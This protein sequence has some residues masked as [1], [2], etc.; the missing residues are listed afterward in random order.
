VRVALA[1][2]LVLGAAALVAALLA[3]SAAA[4]AERGQGG[5]FAR[6][7]GWLGLLLLGEVIA[8]LWVLGFVPL[9]RGQR[10]LGAD[11]P[12]TAAL[13]LLLLV[14]GSAMRLAWTAHRRPRPRRVAALLL[15][16]LAA[17]GLL[18]AAVIQV[19]RRPTA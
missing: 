17:A 4:A 14:L 3:W 8:G 10:L 9:S 6:R 1:F 2:H 5:P 16:H 15:A 12:G 7:T 18:M 11:G 19:L 13:V